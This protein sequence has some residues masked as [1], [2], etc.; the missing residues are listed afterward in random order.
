MIRLRLVVSSW[1]ETDALIETGDGISSVAYLLASGY[2]A[3]LTVGT[4]RFLRFQA[5]GKCASH[6]RAP[7][8]YLQ[9][10]LWNAGDV[11]V[12]RYSACQTVLAPTYQ[13]E[14][15]REEVN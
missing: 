3:L 4:R 7:S 15:T 8:Q 14:M 11:C 9:L 2:W 1:A 10:Q 6:A 5:R 12:M 13:R